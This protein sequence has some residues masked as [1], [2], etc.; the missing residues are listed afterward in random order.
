MQY[1]YYFCDKSVNKIGGNRNLT[2]AGGYF[3]RI[4]DYWGVLTKTEY[5]EKMKNYDFPPNFVCCFLDYQDKNKK[6]IGKEETIVYFS[7]TV[8]T[9]IMYL[10]KKNPDVEID[11]EK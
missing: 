11:Y 3:H 7:D 4:S 5:E 10:I 1:I 8:V 2:R 6:L 9:A